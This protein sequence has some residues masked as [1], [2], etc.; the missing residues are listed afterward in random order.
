MDMVVLCLILS[1]QNKSGA[2]VW[3]SVKSLGR[4]SRSAILVMLEQLAYFKHKFPICHVSY[5]EIS[6]LTAQF[7][8]TVATLSEH[9]L[10]DFTDAW[11]KL[12]ASV[13]SQRFYRC[14]DKD[15]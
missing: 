10:Y 15:T 14:L 1:K 4:I 7:K 5:T 2:L 12:W 8:P 11:G 6:R 9:L 13:E 3:A